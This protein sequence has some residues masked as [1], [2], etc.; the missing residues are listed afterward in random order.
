LIN[1]TSTDTGTQTVRRRWVSGLIAAASLG[2]A[3]AVLT[4]VESASGSRVAHGG[5]RA[6]KARAGGAFPSLEP[7]RA[8]RGW[9]SATIASGAATLFYPA[10]WKP[11]PGDKG[12]VTASLRDSEG[13]YLGYLNVTPRQGAEQLA[14]WAAFRTRRNAEEGDK[15]V[16]IVAAGENVRFAKA[17]GSCV[18]DD[19]LSKVGSNPYRELA[20]IVTGARHTSVFVGAALMG[21]W[22]T[23][24][25]VL[26]R[27]GSAL[28]ER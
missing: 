4:S 7:S 12:T 18:I 6:T 5:A 25:H 21:A 13:R 27:A 9:T 10:N 8:P 17:R 20:C 24:G 22:P 1:M 26:E 3:V 16:R 19:Y 23:L 2:V 14:G 15:H 28:I 11:I